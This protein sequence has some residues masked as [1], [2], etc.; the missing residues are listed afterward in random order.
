MDARGD[1]IENPFHNEVCAVWPRWAARSGVLGRTHMSAYGC[2]LRPCLAL[3]H[4]TQPTSV[5]MK[6]VLSSISEIDRE[7]G[8]QRVDPDTG[9]PFQRTSVMTHVA[10]VPEAWVEAAE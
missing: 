1:D 7:L 10:W 5:I 9:Q 4:R 3:A 2:D 6:G 8:A